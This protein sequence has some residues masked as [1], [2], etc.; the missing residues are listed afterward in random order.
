MIFLLKYISLILPLLL[1]VALLTLL[2]RKILSAIQR[3]KGPNLV[4]Y[5]G[6]LQAFSDALKLLIK[7]LIIPI[8]V[9]KFLFFLAP[10]I[11]FVLALLIWVIIP[12]EYGYVL[13]DINIGLLYIF[14]ISS[15]SVYGIIIAGWASNSRYAFLGALRSTAQM[16][17]YEV[18]IGLILMSIIVS[19]GSLN[20]TEIVFF[21]K[22]CIWFIIPY[23]PLFLMFIITMLAETNRS[24][25]DLP[26]AEAESVS[27]FNTEYSSAGFALFF[28]AEYTNIIFMSYLC[29]IL[30]F[31]GWDSIIYNNKVLNV[32][33]FTLKSIIIML[34]FIF[35]RAA[36]PRFRY[37]QLMKLGWKIF[38]PIAFSY[39]I[40]INFILYFFNGL[41]NYLII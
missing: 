15:L 41:C 1:S 7:E 3:R 4:G 12:F 22:N 32:F 11:S 39:F 21:Q 8:L 19:V 23:F 38:L 16:I 24:P 2:E 5:V 17:S 10:L 28:I 31:G 36:F 14:A 25:F 30:F 29:I 27:G 26:E 40:S 20:L 34:I 9:N 35:V 6:L 18:S 13:V 33:I 37:D